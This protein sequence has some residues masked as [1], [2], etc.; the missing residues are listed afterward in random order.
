[1]Q[2]ARVESCTEWTAS[3]V[4]AF[5]IE[6]AWV[7]KKMP[8]S[9][10]AA[11][12]ARGNT[13]PFDF[14]QEHASDSDRTRARPTPKQIDRYL[15]ILDWLRLVKSGFDRELVFRVADWFDGEAPGQNERIRW[16]YLIEKHRYTYSRYTLAR[17]YNHALHVIAG[18]LNVN[19]ELTRAAGL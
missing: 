18:N 10:R 16:S 7:L 2:A 3:Q 5:L 12:A 13:W 11:V 15:P 14:N 6:A 4:Q 9:E 1:M 19:P 8:D 17:R